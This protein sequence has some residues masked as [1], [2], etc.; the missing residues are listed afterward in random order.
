VTYTAEEVRYARRY[1]ITVAEA[2][3]RLGTDS[4]SGSGSSRAADDFTTSPANPAS[5]VG[6]AIYGS[7]SDSGPSTS[8][9]SSSSDSGAGSCS[10]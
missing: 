10:E 7:S 5:P 9:S 8:C 3:R 6:Q 1:N 2:R 4:G